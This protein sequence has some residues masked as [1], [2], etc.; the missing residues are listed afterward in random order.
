MSQK[1]TQLTVVP[2]KRLA[3]TEA[4]YKVN[5]LYWWLAKVV[6]GQ[7]S[8]DSREIAEYGFFSIDDLMKLD[9]FP[10]TRWFFSGL[11]RKHLCHCEEGL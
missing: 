9:L 7:I 10:Q 11:L 6:D 5:R 8:C 3:T 1:E 2:I 4:D